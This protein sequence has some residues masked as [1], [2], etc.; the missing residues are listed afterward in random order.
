M[1]QPLKSALI[2]FP[3]CKEEEKFMKIMEQENICSIRRQTV[4]KLQCTYYITWC[5]FF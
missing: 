4:Q 3:E 2:T 5:C 1:Y